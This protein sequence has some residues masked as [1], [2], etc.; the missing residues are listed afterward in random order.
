MKPG[1]IIEYASTIIFGGALVVGVLYAA[2]GFIYTGIANHQNRF[3]GTAEING[4]RIAYHGT[5]PY[6]PAMWFSGQDRDGN[7]T[8]EFAN[9]GSI[10]VMDSNLEEPGLSLEDRVTL[11]LP[12]GQKIEFN[13]SGVYND[14]KYYPFQEGSEAARFLR[15][16]FLEAKGIHK[17]VESNFQID[18]AKK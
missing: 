5:S 14:G 2:A 12:G 16:L 7:A 3:Q 13:S 9:D 15:G 1:K 4:K 18:T 17:Q 10:I 6:E 8:F 11:R